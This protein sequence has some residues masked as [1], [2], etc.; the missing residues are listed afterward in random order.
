MLFYK[1]IIKKID[2]MEVLDENGNTI[3]NRKEESKTEFFTFKPN[4]I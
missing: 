2:K 4:T 3:S 1:I